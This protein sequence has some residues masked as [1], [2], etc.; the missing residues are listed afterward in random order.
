ML[1]PTLLIAL[2]T[3]SGAALSQEVA[4]KFSFK[5]PAARA[6]S[7][8]TGL[9]KASGVALSTAG[10]VGED[11]LVLN[12]SD[13]TVAE[14]MRRIAETLHAEWQKE[15]E[16]YV[17]SRGTT[18]DAQDRR[19]EVAAKVAEFRASLK[20]IVEEHKK[21]GGFNEESAK[22]LAATQ[23]KMME[24]LERQS[25]GGGGT[26]RISGDFTNVAQ[27]TPAAHA[28]VA[29]LSRLTDSQIAAIVSGN[30]NVF[31]LNP[32]RMQRPMPN[33]ANQIL[34]K[35]VADA[36]LYRD[37]NQRNQPSQP[38]QGNRQVIVNG[39][40]ADSTGDGDIS[41][42][43]G[44]A[45]LI[46]QPNPGGSTNVTTSLLVADPNGRT[47]ASGQ[48]FLG[49]VPSTQQQPTIQA[50]ANEKPIELS[51][52]SKELA[53]ALSQI[54]GSMGGGSRAVRMVSVAVGSGSG[55]NMTFTSGGGDGKTPSLSA[56]LKQRV[57]NPDEFDPLSFAPGEAMS[58]SAES[59]GMDLVAYLPDTSFNPLTFSAANGNPTAS[60]FLQ[61]AKT[62]GALNVKEDAGWLLVSPREPA[63]ARERR[64]NRDALAKALQTLD[65][66]GFLNLDDWAAF[67][68]KQTKAPRF[69]EIDD[70]YL[71]LV[72]SP[73]ADSGLNQFSFGG[74]WQTLQFYASLSTGQRQAMVNNRRVPLGTLT[75]YQTGIVSDQVFNSF[76][77][78]IVVNP[79]QSGGRMAFMGGLM[80]ATTER[81]LILP[82]GLPRDGFLSFNV[83][84]RDA[85][86]A[87]S[88]T[89]GG[90]KFLTADAL[91]FERL[92]SERPELAS[93]GAMTTYDQ[94][95]MASQRSIMFAF[96][97]TP[98]VSLTRQLEDNAPGNQAFGAYNRLPARFRD[99]VDRLVEELRK[100]WGQGGGGGNQVPPPVSQR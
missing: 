16:G 36:Q 78:P 42:G 1:R 21:A 4:A 7:L 89:S 31:A 90:S 48:F 88:T 56:E 60:R 71:K 25:S 44:Y 50:P 23:R 91:A 20:R 85:V 27:Q 58:Q 93:W 81:T 95:R 66:K 99:E 70:S 64:V 46:N 26:F 28:I 38:G 62:M 32:T 3:L 49:A 35:F 43:I 83:Q 11:V 12:L 2:A 100:S 34:R 41:L 47:L 75:Q 68:S 22:K 14:A 82:N 52:M 63:G 5:A 77:G 51:A 97:F 18:L 69:N 87:N 24:D 79:R 37:A 65:D 19:V 45:F 76:E 74:G 59:K 92:R 73:A 30:R 54:G 80:D 10:A 86:Q 9:S 40:G 17:L 29:L 61:S 67:A 96:Q 53:L 55:G 84:G 98:M 13:V 94:Y 57:L 33:G 6:K 8:F 15:G 72:N 39:F